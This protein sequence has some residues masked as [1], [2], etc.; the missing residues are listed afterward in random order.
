MLKSQDR[1]VQQHRKASSMYRDR[2]FAYHYCTKDSSGQSTKQILKSI[3]RQVVHS[4]LEGTV[5]QQACDM[6]NELERLPFE[7]M[8]Q[9]ECLFEGILNAGIKIRIVLDALDEYDDWEE[10]LNALKRL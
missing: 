6:H 1:I 5:A 4:P 9:C 3:L 8:K 7:T 2:R 10:T